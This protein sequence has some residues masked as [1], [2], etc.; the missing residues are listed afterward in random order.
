MFMRRLFPALLLVL[1]SVALIAAVGSRS[2]AGS[3]A[4][5]DYS[6]DVV[7]SAFYV[8]DAGDK[9]GRHDCQNGKCTCLTCCSACVLLFVAPDSFFL[10]LGAQTALA[11]RE[12]S[13][14]D[15]ITVQPVTGPPKLSAWI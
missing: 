7:L 10:Q 13:W 8:E 11:I 12:N 5:H 3:T 14:L 6:G 1:A 9:C 2:F 4:P 15:G